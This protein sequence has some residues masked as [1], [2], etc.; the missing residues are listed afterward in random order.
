MMIDSKVLGC[1]SVNSLK[2]EFSM[3][4]GRKSSDEKTFISQLFCRIKKYNHL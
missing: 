1:V 3:F 2:I 4:Q